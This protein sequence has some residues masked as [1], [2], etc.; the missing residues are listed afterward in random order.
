MVSGHGTNKR[1]MSSLNIEYM[2]KTVTKD[3]VRFYNNYAF[4]Q[5]GAAQ[6]EEHNTTKQNCTTSAILNRNVTAE[7]DIALCKEN[8]QHGRTQ[9]NK[10]RR[11]TQRRRIIEFSN[12][13]T[14]V[15]HTA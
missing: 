14:Y 2:F 7:H 3:G 8:E 9:P 13:V 15:K 12:S 6:L 1:S 11:S 5:H 10:T 4:N